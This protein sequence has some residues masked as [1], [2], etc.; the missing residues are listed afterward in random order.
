MK[1][2]IKICAGASAL[3]AGCGMFATKPVVNVA[4]AAELGTV[5][6]VNTYTSTQ[7]NFTFT[8]VSLPKTV[9][10][11]AKESFYIPYPTVSDSSYTVKI[12]VKDGSNLYTHTKGETV[13]QGTETPFTVNEGKTGVNFSYYR[14]TTYK[15]YF[16]A[17][18]DGKKYS[19]SVYNVNV[20]GVKYSYDI[21]NISTVIPT[22]AGVNDKI[23]LPTLTVLDANGDV[24]KEN[25]NPVVATP[26]V[27]RNN[28]EI[29]VEDEDNDVLTLEDG[30]YYFTAENLGT[31]TVS[32]STEKYSVT[33]QEI[34]IDVESWFDSSKVELEIGTLTLSNVD[35]NIEK[36]LPTAKVSDG[37]HTYDGSTDVPHTTEI[38]I[39]DENEAKVATLTGDEIK[40]YTF[41]TA[42]KYICLAGDP[43]LRRIPYCGIA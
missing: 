40:S 43:Q 6:S 32:Y 2:I 42:G 28:N 37:Y 41:K 11:E 1:K 18:K 16:T 7:N 24:V 27:Y 33:P 26:K 22:V 15:V 19:S 35:L 20:V 4:N 12:N 31:Y 14:N 29:K 5:S 17:E 38:T 13:E 8:S 34:N 39:F 3:I 9:N 36:E 30:K 10:A 23:L 21:E 25:E